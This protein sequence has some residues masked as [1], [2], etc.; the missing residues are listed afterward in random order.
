MSQKKHGHNFETQNCGRDF[1]VTS[2]IFG[3]G[4][5]ISKSVD[6]EQQKLPFGDSHIQK[7]RQFRKAQDLSFLMVVPRIWVPIPKTRVNCPNVKK[8]HFFAF[9]G[10]TLQKNF[11]WLPIGQ[12]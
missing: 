1:F 5:Q 7:V 3:D 12:F 8:K 2:L 6:F 4:P 9:F 11:K 10:V